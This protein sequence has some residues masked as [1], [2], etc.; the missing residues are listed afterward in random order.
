MYA[1]SYLDGA[2]RV[3]II[4]TSFIP[5]EAGTASVRLNQDYGC[6]QY[7]CRASNGSDDAGF[8]C[9]YYDFSLFCTPCAVGSVST[10]GRTCAVPEC[11]PDQ[12]LTPDQRTCIDCPRDCDGIWSTCS[13]DCR[14]D[15]TQTAAPSGAGA[16][17]PAAPRCAAGEDDCP[18][19]DTAFAVELFAVI[20]VLFVCCTPRSPLSSENMPLRNW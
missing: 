6:E 11:P 20:V 16:A 7:P 4:N 14:R 17:C 10:D 1:S 9:S 15:W 18:L 5:V 19:G 8:G 12:C 3:Y 13:S 2:E